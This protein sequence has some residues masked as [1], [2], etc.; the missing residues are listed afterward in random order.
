MYRIYISLYSGSTSYS[1]VNPFTNSSQY[2][3]R[4]AYR[5]NLFTCN[6]IARREVPPTKFKVRL[7]STA[8]DTGL[9]GRML[10]EASL[11]QASYARKRGQ[12][13]EI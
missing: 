7:R 10:T 13:E 8:A 5:Q 6:E 3:Q 4:S 2:S 12:N 1:I 11:E 9:F